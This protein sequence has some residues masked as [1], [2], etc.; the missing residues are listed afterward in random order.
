VAVPILRQDG[1][2][3]ASIQ[4]A[5]SDSD[6]EL[7]RRELLAKAGT[8]GT[9]G[10]VVDLTAMDVLDSFASRTLRDLVQM[11]RLRGSEAVIVGIQPDVAFAMAQLGLRLDGVSTALDLDEGVEALNA[12][13]PRRARD[14]GED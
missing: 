5:L 2:L 9:R 10:A 12:K 14:D 3:V 8:P 13:V 4:S 6:W 7:F 1:V 11:L